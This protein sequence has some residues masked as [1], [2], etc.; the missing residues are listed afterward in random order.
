MEADTLAPRQTNEI[1][2]LVYWDPGIDIF[3]I[4]GCQPGLRTTI[5]NGFS[6]KK[7]MRKINELG[8]NSS[9]KKER[10]KKKT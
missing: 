7:E 3:Q 6:R 5:L 4:S 2:V 9:Y 8:S 1:R 10:K